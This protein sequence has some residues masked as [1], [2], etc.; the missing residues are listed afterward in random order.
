MKKPQTKKPTPKQLAEMGP[1]EHTIA[2]I[3]RG[4]RCSNCG[5]SNR[6]G[7]HECPRK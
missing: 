4:P 6:R 7:D 2:E 5:R 3:E 1:L